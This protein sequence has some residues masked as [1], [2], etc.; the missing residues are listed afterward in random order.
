LDFKGKEM[1][2]SDEK[3]QD[4]P[5]FENL[6]GILLFP[7]ERLSSGVQKM[8]SCL[9]EDFSERKETQRQ[10]LSLV[11]EGIPIPKKRARH[12]RRGS[13]VATYDPQEKEKQEFKNALLKSIFH[14]NFKLE[15]SNFELDRFFVVNMSFYLPIPDS[16]SN[17]QK[18]AKKWH[19]QKHV[20][21]PDIDNLIKFVLDCGNGILFQDDCLVTQISAKKCYSINPRTEINLYIMEKMNLH[22]SAEKIITVFEPIEL[23]ELTRDMN[24]IVQLANDFQNGLNESQKKSFYALMADK[25]SCFARKHNA[26][27]QK[28]K[29]YQDFELTDFEKKEFMENIY[30]QD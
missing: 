2:F 8:H 7:S 19:I 30:G 3:V 12:V 9:A 25:L 1:L 6:R 16:D 22:Q 24:S 29:K 17:A 11:I 27:L 20:I 4:L 26:Q 15:A 21:K 23:W 13:F 5:S 14:S 18:N 28:I 10:V